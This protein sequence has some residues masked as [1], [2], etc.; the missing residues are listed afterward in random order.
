MG[1]TDEHGRLPRA[2]RA[3]R[4][5]ELAWDARQRD[6]RLSCR[7]RTDSTTQFTEPA[8]ESILLT[9]WHCARSLRGRASPSPTQ[10][11]SITQ[12]GVISVPSPRASE[13]QDRRAEQP[14]AAWYRGPLGA[15]L[16]DKLC[17]KNDFAAKREADWWESIAPGK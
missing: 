3:A 6:G 11:A 8:L 2:A 12:Y 15:L 5:A 7:V 17:F 13:G 9:I 10:A 14:S 4:R 16:C 1:P